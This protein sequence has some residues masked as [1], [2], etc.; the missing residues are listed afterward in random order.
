[1]T[2]KEKLRKIEEITR[3]AFNNPDTLDINLYRA[4]ALANIF[5][6]FEYGEALEGKSEAIEE[7]FEDQISFDDIL[8]EDPE[9]AEALLK[10]CNDMIEDILPKITEAVSFICS[11]L[12]NGTELL[13]KVWEEFSKNENNKID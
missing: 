8:R 11:E 3:E 5:H 1:M 10:T 9:V 12:V 13:S 2:D 4:Q 6:I 7:P